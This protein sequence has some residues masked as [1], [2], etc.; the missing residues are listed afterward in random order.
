MRPLPKGVVVKETRWI[1]GRSGYW[2]R[3]LISSSGYMQR[4]SF[5]SLNLQPSRY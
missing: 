1:Y 3:Q 5:I 4:R 2:P